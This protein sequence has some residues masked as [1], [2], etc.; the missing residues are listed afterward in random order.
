MA[1]A[2]FHR[3]SAGTNLQD[4]CWYILLVEEWEGGVKL[5]FGSR[6]PGTG[7]DGSAVPSGWGIRTLG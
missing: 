5:T 3:A 4:F 6:N 7:R 1:M 2:R